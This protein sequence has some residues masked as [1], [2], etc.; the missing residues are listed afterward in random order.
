MQAGAAPCARSSCWP[1]PWSW[2]CTAGGR[3]GAQPA[4]AAVEQ[5]AAPAS[6]A[7]APAA[8][9]LRDEALAR[10]MVGRWHWAELSPTM[11]LLMEIIY[12]DDGSFRAA[13]RS[14]TR[15][16]PT[17]DT[18]AMAMQIQLAGTWVIDGDVCVETVRAS[19][20]PLGM[21]PSIDRDRITE[22]QPDVHTMV[23]L[24]SG[25]TAVRQRRPVAEAHHLA[26]AA[27]AWPAPVAGA[28]WQQVGA[29][30]EAT[31]WIDPSSVV[32]MGDIVGLWTRSD[33]SPEALQN[34]RAMGA[35]VPPGNR[36]VVAEQVLF[37]ILVDCRRQW[38]KRQ[39]VRIH[40]DGRQVDGSTYKKEDG[41]QWQRIEPDDVLVAAA[42]RQVCTAP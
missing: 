5:P 33:M 7:T 2:D 23:S 26:A 36:V 31:F 6:A 37:Y 13:I 29:D 38:V 3:S 16:D 8:L 18:W 40:M 25:R 17:R 27:L 32:R 41:G 19:S 20:V 34:A 11:N 39:E 14:F 15:T 21:L 4:A 42:A 30:A 1:W 24:A 22:I 28:A 35:K 12:V 10:Y 9:A